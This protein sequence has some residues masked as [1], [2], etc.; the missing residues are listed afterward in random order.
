[1]TTRTDWASEG[2]A[3]IGSRVVKCFDEV[4]Y[5]GQ[6][7]GWKAAAEGRKQDWLVVYHDG[8]SD[9]MEDCELS[10]TVSFACILCLL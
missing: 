3:V 10:A 4:P 8:D 5:L 6:V 7:V 1:M 9:V 2:Q